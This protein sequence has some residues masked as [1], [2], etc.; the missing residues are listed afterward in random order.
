MKDTPSADE[1]FRDQAGHATVE[2]IA[3]TLGR[4]VWDGYDNGTQIFRTLEAWLAGADREKVAVALAFDEAFLW[5]STDEM[6]R[7]LA[8]VE[9]RFPEFAAKC[10]AWRARWA[11][12]PQQPQARPK[13]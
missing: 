7:L 6:E 12:L 4:L 11:A 1:V 9:S 2:E 13:R 10:S 3:E 8:G 5:Q